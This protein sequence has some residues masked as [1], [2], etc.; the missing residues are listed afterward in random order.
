MRCGVGFEGF[1]VLWCL[2]GVCFEGFVVGVLCGF[3]GV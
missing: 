2:V 1:V 3:R